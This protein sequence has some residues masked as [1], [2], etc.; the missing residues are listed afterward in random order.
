M[1]SHA[2]TVTSV[3]LGLAAM[4]AVNIGLAQWIGSAPT[5][6]DAPEAPGAP[7]APEVGPPEIT[8]TV[9]MPPDRMPAL[10]I[11]ATVAQGGALTPGIV[12]GSLSQVIIRAVGPTLAQFAV[13]NPMADPKVTVYNAQGT[14]VAT[15]D[16][17]PAIYSTNFAAVGQFALPYGSKDAAIILNLAPGNYTARVES[18]DPTQGGEVL[19]EVYLVPYVKVG[20]TGD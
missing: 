5:T 4:L 18:V 17:W 9:D 3:I 14:V 10:S 12:V 20:V 11:R 2:R 7:L 13:T 8:T 15:N 16:N 19:L 6:S 1:T